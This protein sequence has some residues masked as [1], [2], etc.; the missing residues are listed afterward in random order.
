[1]AARDRLLITVISEQPTTTTA[2]TASL[3]L[4]SVSGLFNDGGNAAWAT[5]RR[6]R[7]HSVPHSQVSV[8]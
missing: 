7:G 3:T 4:V 1:M 5:D 2:R 8:G 6:T